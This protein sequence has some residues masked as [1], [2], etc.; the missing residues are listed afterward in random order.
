M[1]KMQQKNDKN[2]SHC[3][4]EHMSKRHFVMAE[5]SNNNQNV[6]EMRVDLGR[7][8]AVSIN[9]DSICNISTKQ[10]SIPATS[11]LTFVFIFDFLRLMSI[12]F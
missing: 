6:V 10:S 9:Y 3:A 8:F 12:N 1:L 2:L 4:N 5:I 7:A 11:A